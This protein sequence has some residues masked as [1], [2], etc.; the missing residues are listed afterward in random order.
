MEN[1]TT[2]RAVLEDLIQVLVSQNKE[3]EKLAE[4]VGKTTAH[5]ARVDLPLVT[6][7][8]SELSHRI[9]RLSPRP[10]NPEETT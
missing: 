9:K 7:Q 10:E 2:L 3:I 1:S 6:S 8:L 4:H 5:A